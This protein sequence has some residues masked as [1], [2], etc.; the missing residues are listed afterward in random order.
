M[1][2][3]GTSFVAIGVDLRAKSRDGRRLFAELLAA[4]DDDFRRAAVV[5][6]EAGGADAGAGRG[7]RAD[8]GAVVSPD[9]DGEELVRVRRVEI[10]EGGLAV[11]VGRGVFTGDG[12][13]DG[14][15][16]AFVVLGLG[17]GE[18]LGLRDGGE[19]EEGCGEFQGLHI[20]PLGCGLIAERRG[21]GIFAS[22]R[23]VN[24][25]VCN[26]QQGIARLRLHNS[27]L[28]AD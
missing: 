5:L 6:D 16:L 3:E 19:Q 2:G 15:S 4:I 14:G 12:A 27:W 18:G 24:T 13:A 26:M 21:R 28:A 20:F 7:Q 22:K 17:G 1:K 10:D 11:A 23:E 9:E 25:K 8:V